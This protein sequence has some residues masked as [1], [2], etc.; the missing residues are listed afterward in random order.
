MYFNI[1]GRTIQRRIFTII[2]LLSFLLIFLKVSK[3][4][5]CDSNEGFTQELPF[6]FKEGDEVFDEFYAEIYSIIHK[7]YLYVDSITE[8]VVKYSNIDV[9]KSSLLVI[10]IDT[11]EQ[12]NSFQSKGINT[13]SVIKYQKMFLQSQITFPHLRI[14]VDNIENPMIYEKS[15]FSHIFCSGTVFYT[16]EAK[17]KL[18]RNMYNWLKPDGILLL[19]LSDRSKFDTILSSKT[20]QIMDSPQKYHNERITDL[21]IDFGSFKYL[22]KYDFKDAEKKNI[23]YFTD[24]FT[25]TNTQHVRKNEQILYMENVDDIIKTVNQ[26]GFSVLRKINLIHDINQFIYVLERKH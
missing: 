5:Y 12:S 18:L 2:V 15:T 10:S 17:T 9:D 11:G 24:T 20:S 4:A 16:I 6:I 14:K 3:N 7:P 1:L 21:E 8:Q 25:D 23:V 22:S 26:C 19:Q 13:F